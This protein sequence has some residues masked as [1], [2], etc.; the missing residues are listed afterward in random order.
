M[1]DFFPSTFASDTFVP[2][3]GV[4]TEVVCDNNSS[5]FNSYSIININLIDNA[6]YLQD[7]VNK[8]K[9]KKKNTELKLGYFWQHD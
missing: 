1:S 8:N 7:K 2:K 6:N 4:A 5:R 3:V 9:K